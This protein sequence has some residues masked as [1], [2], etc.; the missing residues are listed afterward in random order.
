M[1][2]EC[3]IIADDLTGACD[4]A[5]AFAQ[6]G[7]RTA[8]R[9]AFAGREECADVLSIST[10]SRDFDTAGIR[11]AM[12]S[13][14]R[15]TPFASARLIF[16]KIDSTLRGQ[17]ATE[18]ASALA[19][20][21]CDVAVVCPAYPGTGRVVDSGYLKVADDSTF[22]PVE[23]AAYLRSQGLAGC[24]QTTP[25]ATLQ[26]IS[27]GAR[28]LSFDANA[29]EDLERIVEACLA[30]PFRVLWAG[31]GGLAAAL[32]RRLPLRDS[33]PPAI[34]TKAGPVLFCVGSDHAATAVQQTRLLAARPCLLVSCEDATPESIGSALLR[35]DHVLLR[36]PRGRVS[37]GRIVELTAGAPTAAVLL[38]GGDTASFFCGSAGVRRI[39]LRGEVAPGIPWGVI[40]GSGLTGL[41][42]VTKS[43]GFGKPDTL[44]RVADF[45][46]CRT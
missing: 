22:Q 15:S 21:E 18:I 29:D 39:D 34:R 19:A 12:A 28:F 35:G 20:F 32:A 16:K 10:D 30:I 6:R 7:Y 9:I 43:G 3:L 1:T 13:A 5:V 8:V 45:F 11:D 37:A 14:A 23:V 17:V 26:A 33:A 38:S 24:V 31:A 25:Q 42:V 4:A 27:S 46:A 41:P 44:V 36:V 2:L 40:A